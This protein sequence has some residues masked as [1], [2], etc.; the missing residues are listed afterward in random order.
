MAHGGRERMCHMISHTGALF[1]TVNAPAA[2]AAKDLVAR[3]GDRGMTSGAQPT[4]RD[5]REGE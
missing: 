1:L 3:E 5:A 4:T 2:E